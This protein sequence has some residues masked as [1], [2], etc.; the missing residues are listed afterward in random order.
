MP[1]T[2]GKVSESQGEVEHRT[3]EISLEDR[4][5]IRSARGG[6]STGWLSHARECVVAA[7]AARQA[8]R[9]AFEAAACWLSLLLTTERPVN[10]SG[11]GPCQAMSLAPMDASWLPRC[12]R[13]PRCAEIRVC[14]AIIEGA[15]PHR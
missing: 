4:E 5:R 9:A 11:S 12:L 7:R 2:L 14:D 13:F 8:L 15:F 3:Q 1:A 10:S 6:G